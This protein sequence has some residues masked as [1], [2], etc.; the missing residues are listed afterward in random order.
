MATD[1]SCFICDEG[2]NGEIP[3]PQCNTAAWNEYHERH[4]EIVTVVER[5][6]C[7]HE[8]RPVMFHSG[9]DYYDGL[10]C[11]ICRDVVDV[12]GSPRVTAETVE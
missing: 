11:A 7:S 5:G 4:K 3:C 12:Q 1:Q 6:R 2:Y 10:Y 8:R 9:D